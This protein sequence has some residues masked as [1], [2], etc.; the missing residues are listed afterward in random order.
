LVLAKLI[1]LYSNDGGILIKDGYGNNE[2]NRLHYRGISVEDR[3]PS[4]FQALLQCK[5]SQDDHLLETGSRL[6]HIS[7]S[8]VV[9]F[10]VILLIHFSSATSRKS[11]FFVAFIFIV[12][13]RHSYLAL[14]ISISTS[15]NEKATF[16]S[17]CNQF[18]S[19][20]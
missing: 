12:L 17:R 7:A 4:F 10:R 9:Q 18:Q 2:R 20:F 6:I 16:T 13:I 3:K 15:P 11:S 1:R 14:A 19:F 5:K 8:T